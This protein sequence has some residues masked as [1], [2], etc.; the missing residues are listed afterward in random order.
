[1]A[2]RRKVF[3]KRTGKYAR[4]FPDL[5]ASNI[6]MKIRLLVENAII[7]VKAS[8]CYKDHKK[9]DR[10]WLIYGAKSQGNEIIETVDI[11]LDEIAKLQ[12][13]VRDAT[14]EAI[15]SNIKANAFDK[16]KERDLNFKR[17]IQKSCSG[18]AR[19]VKEEKK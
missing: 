16:P 18:L 15:E 2:R 12:N 9:S 11:L 14:D 1:M 19:P 6:E 5:I 17:I 10:Y 8:K 7:G 13:T 3:R 4:K